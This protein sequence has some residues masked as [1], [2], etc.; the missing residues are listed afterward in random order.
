MRT[1]T[2]LTLSLAALAAPALAEIKVSDPYARSAT[3]MAKA[4]AA[5]MMIEN[6]AEAADRLI[7]ASSAAAAKVE[8]HTH[9]EED[10]VMKMVHVEEGIE[11]P[12]S[13]AAMLKRGGYHVM[14]MGLTS[15]WEQG[16]MIPVTLTFEGAGDISLEVMVD[17]ER[18]DGGH[19]G[20]MNQ[21]EMKK[22]GDHSGHG[23]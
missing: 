13:G 20:Q 19:G 10:G 1:L 9:I 15:G 2:A 21:S 23:N 17:R 12:A 3:P 6:T 7:G 5:F 16:D 11:I 4:G 22:D 18:K 8:L 14:F